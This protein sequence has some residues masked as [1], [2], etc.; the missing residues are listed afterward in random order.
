[1]AH[2][3]NGQSELA[4]ADADRAEELD[5]AKSP[6][7]RANSVRV[8]NTHSMLLRANPHPSSPTGRSPWVWARKI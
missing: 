4:K 2:E 1:M 5:P 6:T 3:D 8:Q 7:N